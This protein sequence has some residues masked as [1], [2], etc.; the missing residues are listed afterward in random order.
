MKDDEKILRQYIRETIYHSQVKP[1]YPAQPAGY[2]YRLPQGSDEFNDVEG[3]EDLSAAE[4][5]VNIRTDSGQM[6]YSARPRDLKE[7][8][9]R[10][11]IARKLQEQKKRS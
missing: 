11:I 6:S 7:R 8:A 5:A 2:E 10:R 9:L 3:L 4:N 1:L